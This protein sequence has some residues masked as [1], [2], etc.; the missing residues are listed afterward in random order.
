M[1][2]WPTPSKVVAVNTEDTRR[3]PMYG[4]GELTFPVLAFGNDEFFER[5][6]H[7]EAH[8]HP[9]HE[10]LWNETGAGTAFIGRRTWTV[11]GRVALWIPA[12]MPH[13]GRTPAGSRQ[14]AVHFSSE[15]PAL[16]PGPVAVELS[17]LLRLLLVRLI[18]EDLCDTSHRL[19]EQ[20]VLDV[21]TPSTR[22]LV[23]QM[24]TSPLIMPI[25]EVIRQ[26][27]ADQ[28]TLSAWARRLGVSTRT[29]TRTF[30]AETGLGFSRW[31]ATARAQYAVA[32]LGHDLSVAEVA[33]CVGYCSA[34][35]F[36]TAFR[37]ITG[38]T[39]GQFR[40]ISDTGDGVEGELPGDLVR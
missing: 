5:D 17:P 36:T 26:N 38:M 16:A 18:D 37:R 10:L 6:T 39:P 14:R 29:V 23:L 40:E 22:E 19:T 12:G 33:Q 15:T 27:P 31:V 25:V 2:C 4:A 3:L 13:T 1:S 30:E 24:P 21:I 11:T 8:S 20:M 35:S 7:W 32:L 9:T 28:T 34:S